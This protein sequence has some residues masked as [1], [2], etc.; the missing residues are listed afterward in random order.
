MTDY[1]NLID[2]GKI[3]PGRF[4]EK[5]VKDR[6]DLAE[7]DLSIAKDVLAS[8]PE[9][10][11]N[12]AYNAMHQSGRALMLHEGYRTVGEG[13]HVTVIRFLEIF[14]GNGYEKPLQLMDRMR[15]QR[16]RATYD[17]AGTISKTQADEAL[18]TAKEFVSLIKRKIAPDKYA[19]A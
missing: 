6:L 2:A 1:S 16:N 19:G 13:H 12:I 9:W 5:Q 8:S 3:A 17:M 7:R 15:R 18:E 14:L 11:F 4:S 10:S